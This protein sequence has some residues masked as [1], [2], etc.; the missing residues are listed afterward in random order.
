MTIG[1][2]ATNSGGWSTAGLNHCSS[3]PHL[4][5]IISDCWI[6]PKISSNGPLVIK[7]PISI[8]TEGSYLVIGKGKQVE[9]DS[10]LDTL[11][12]NMKIKSNDIESSSSDM[13]IFVNKFGNNVKSNDLS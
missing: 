5:S 11:C 6:N 1:Q 8:P 3:T 13:K 10:S 2:L 7:E 4:Y 12:S 9:I